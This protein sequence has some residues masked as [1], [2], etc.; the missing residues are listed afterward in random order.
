M[1]WLELDVTRVDAGLA[2]KARGD[3][4]EKEKDGVDALVDTEIGMG[5][6]EDKGLGAFSKSWVDEKKQPTQDATQTS[7]KKGMNRDVFGKDAQQQIR[8]SSYVTG[9]VSS[10]GSTSR[11]I[12]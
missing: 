9:R 12:L 7:P 4:V 3:R 5:E 10:T 2:I 6:T 8:Q 1:D 11:V